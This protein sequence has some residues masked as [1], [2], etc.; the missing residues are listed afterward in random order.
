M[1]KPG[2]QGELD[3]VV[4]ARYY[5]GEE[6]YG[7]RNIKMLTFKIHNLSDDKPKFYITKTYEL[8]PGTLD[9]ERANPTVSLGILPKEIDMSKYSPEEQSQKVSCDVTFTVDSSHRIMVNSTIEVAY[10]AYMI[11]PVENAGY[12]GYTVQKTQAGVALVKL[13]DPDITEFTIRFETAKVGNMTAE[14]ANRRYA[15]MYGR[16]NM[17]DF[18][19][20]RMTARISPGS[21]I[22]RNN[23]TYV[24]AEETNR[25]PVGA[26]ADGGESYNGIYM[27]SI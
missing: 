9:I 14:Y 2:E 17:F 4:Q 25:T 23:N 19:G 21:F 7:Y 1:L 10:P 20:R 24:L 27:H 11:N 18:G 5:V 8:R 26:S 22:I 3:I 15:I 13:T 6:L 16:V 12:V